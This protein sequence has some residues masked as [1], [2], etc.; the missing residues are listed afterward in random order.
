MTTASRRARV[1]RYAE[2]PLGMRFQWG[3]R[4]ADK[5]MPQGVN[6]GCSATS[7]Q[8]ILG[9][10]GHVVSLN[11]IAE[12]VGYPDSRQAKL[13]IGLYDRQVVQ[14]LAHWG[15]MYRLTTDK[16]PTELMRIS[17]RQGPVAFCCIYGQW[18]EWQGYRYYGETADGKPNG[19][20]RPIQAAGKNQLTGF[21]D[22][23]HMGL[24]L[25]KYHRSGTPHEATQVWLRD[26]NHGSPARPEK[27][28]YDIVTPGQ[29][30]RLF[31]TTGVAIV[32]IGAL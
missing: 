22:G 7:V 2:S 23:R 16:T 3:Q 13:H 19:Y 17:V 29:W 28:V 6:T 20:A 1:L 10:H 15:V 14:A 24:L 30:G 4:D 25:S 27:P 18:P 31:R 11:D 8:F 5:F 32:P 9:L 21:E 26:P 12:A